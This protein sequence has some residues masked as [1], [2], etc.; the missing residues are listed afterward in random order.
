[1]LPAFFGVSRAVREKKSRS[2]FLILARERASRELV[3]APLALL[4]E[5]ERAPRYLNVPQDYGHGQ[6]V[7]QACAPY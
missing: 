7:S 5:K 3:T 6:S 4:R 2:G 1:M